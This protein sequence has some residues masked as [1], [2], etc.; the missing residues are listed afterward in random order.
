[1]RGLFSIFGFRN[2]LTLVSHVPARNKAVI[3]LSSR[4][5]DDTCMGEEKDHKP[6]IIMH[7]NA[8]KSRFDIL[9]QL[10]MERTCMRSTRHWLLKLFCS[11]I[12]VACVNAFVLWMLKYPNGQQK[13]NHWIRLYLYLLTYGAM[14]AIG[15]PFQ[16]AVS[17][18]TVKK[19]GEGQL[20]R[21]CSICP[22]AK[23]RRTDCSEWT[24]LSTQIK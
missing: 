6:K 1:V 12:D 15:V 16:R 17:P 14:R 8:T 21:C 13:K 3:L 22:A 20:G 2:D 10:V 9:E 18:S 11:F 4:H 7:N 19:S 5:Y 23:D 24:T